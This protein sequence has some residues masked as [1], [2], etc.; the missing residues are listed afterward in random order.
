M[1]GPLCRRVW[2]WEP[3]SAVSI[4]NRTGC[5]DPVRGSTGIGSGGPGEDVAV[6]PARLQR[7]Q[8]PSA[9]P[10]ERP[11]YLWH[12]SFHRTVGVERLY[13]WLISCQQ[14]FDRESIIPALTTALDSV[15]VRSFVI[16]ELF[17][18]QD[19][20]V[21]TWLPPDIEAG[22][23]EDALSKD[24]R[25]VRGF[26]VSEM[27][28]HWMWDG[29]EAEAQDL[30][31]AVTI[32]A[33][34]DINAS[35]SDANL[36]SNYLQRGFIRPIEGGPYTIKF[37]VFIRRPQDFDADQEQ[38]F[39]TEIVGIAKSFAQL[40]YWSLYRVRGPGDGRY[41][42]TGRVAT[43]NFEGITNELN[44]SINSVG[45]GHVLGAKTLTFIAT[46]SKPR[47]RTERIAPF[48]LKEL[49]VHEVSTKGRSLTEQSSISPIEGLLLHPEGN[50][51]EVKGSAFVDLRRQVHTGEVKN[52]PRVTA[53]I[54]KTIV[55]FLNTDGGTLVIGALEEADF[56]EALD[57]L[58]NAFGE[59][60][61]IDKYRIVG[62]SHEYS[63]KDFDGYEL[64]LRDA[65]LHHVDPS[66][67]AQD[68]IRI[69]RARYEDRDLCVITILE[70]TTPMYAIENPGEIHR[71]YVR[72]G[73]RTME[74]KGS[75]RDAYQRERS[76]RDTYQREHGQQRGVESGSDGP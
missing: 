62:I 65:L 50:H 76:A 68:N 54:I 10:N 31:G 52:D 12:H 51:L 35:T 48:G 69:R 14:R 17:G 24:Q 55:A 22:S 9:S 2:A 3:I 23:V 5:F 13:F 4:R 47:Y 41:I 29:V 63:R 45:K 46:S 40:Q 73:N 66:S 64:A 7:D 58:E 43:D 26:S 53:S 1:P 75:G 16:W 72:Q 39:R 8:R 11:F 44:A 74:L 59:M 20:L 56:Y 25:K 49:S 28:R 70:S 21:R 67:I 38:A 30:F 71:F 15:G 60:P 33:L 27:L 34:A 32:E 36:L 42:L 57:K 19:I 61:V 18:E 37:F 6:S